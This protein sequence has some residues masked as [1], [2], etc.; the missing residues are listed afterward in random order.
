[1]RY[2]HDAKEHARH[3]VEW[4][5]GHSLGVILATVVAAGGTWGF[6]SLAGEVVEG[7]TQAFDVWAVRALRDA[8][9]GQVGPGW[10]HEMGRDATALGGILFLTLLT[11]AVVGFLLIRRQ[12]GA[13]LLVA[14]ATVGGW[15]ISTALKWGFARPR[16]DVVEHLSVVHT[17]SFPSGHSMLSAVVYLTLGGLLTR[18][19]EGN[20]VKAYLL[21][22][23]ILVTILV[24]LSRVYVGVH[25]PTD[26]LAGW[27]AGTVWAM[28]C[29]LAARSLQRRGRVERETEHDDAAVAARAG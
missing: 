2:A 24:G 26:V 6:V 8:D 20:A 23:A 19:V 21:G 22:C 16:P 12:R 18:F 7:D 28:L 4:L 17:S 9:G 29:W 14:A 15:A 13:A 25:Y 10:L 1:M 3:A 5:G 27:T 11:F